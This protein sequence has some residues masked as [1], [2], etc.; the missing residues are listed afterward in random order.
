MVGSNRK[1]TTVARI[2]RALVVLVIVGAAVALSRTMMGCG[3]GESSSAQTTEPSSFP[4]PQV[5]RSSHGVLSLTLRA[6]LA[7]NKILGPAAPAMAAG[8]TS[9][10]SNTMVVGTITGPTYDGKL[11]GPTLIVDPGD[12]LK[13]KL[14]NDLPNNPPVTRTGMYPHEPY[15]TNLHT[16]GLEVSPEGNSDNVLRIMDP[17]TTNRVEIKIP[18]YHHAGTF[19]FHP[20]VHGAVTFQMMGGMAGMLIVRGGVGTVD[21]VKEVKAAKQI[22]MDFQV[23]HTTSANQVA[24]VNPTATQLGSSSPS[25][26]DGVWSAYLPP[27]NTYFTTNGVLNP[28]LHMRPG[29]VQ[30]WRMLNAGSGETLLVALQN[31]P[32]Y[33][34]MNDGINVPNLLTL[35]AGTPY[36]MGAGQRVDLLVKAG[37]PG[38]YLLQCLSP[39]TSASVSPQGIAPAPRSSHISGDFPMPTYPITLA[40]I[41]IDGKP[42]DMALPTE[43]LPPPTGLPSI[44]TMLD[45]TPNAVRN[46]AFELCGVM[47][48]MAPP[49]ARLPSCGWF[50]NK[51]DSNYWGGIPFTS[52]NM[53]R[54]AD[55]TGVPSNPPNPSE[56]LINF[57]KEGLFDDNVPLF[58]DMIVNNFEEWT[59]VNKSFSDHVFHIHQNPF[60]VTQI[61]GIA[62]PVPE[63]H[64]SIIVPAATFPG[65]MVPI[66][67]PSVTFGSITFRT[68]FDPIT[69][70]TFVTHCHVL[71]HEDIGMMQRVDILPA[72]VAGARRQK[73]ASMERHLHSVKK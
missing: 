54:D 7:T 12:T 62:L 13:I 68:H 65:A 28:T 61:N 69:V 17:G 4:Q 47:A 63:W 16:H 67:D 10:A 55:D 2:S 66:T 33:V 3:S 19:W 70:G 73:V 36:V 6:K 25:A 46:I 64:D 48:G 9:D 35:E 26:A 59:I 37:P 38:T 45:T 15:S 22:V 1:S 44:S 11:T 24:Y 51:Y 21:D 39:T 50:L 40:T 43:N 72:P 20:H 8:A 5:L 57:Q 58:D 71:Q 27:S 49:T 23:L 31:H 32:L 42:E 53:I 14:I 52:L 29:E 60:L 41:V 30:R 34:L 56:P 18:K